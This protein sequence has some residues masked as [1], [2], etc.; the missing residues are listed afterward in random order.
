MKR[1]VLVL[2]AVMLSASACYAET[3]KDAVR[4]LKKLEARC[5]AGISYRDYAPA[6]GD[7]KFD[8]NMYI[9]SDEAKNAPE[10]SESIKSAISHYEYA[11]SF[12]AIKFRERRVVDFIDMESIGAKSFLQRYPNPDN[13]I[14]AE[15]QN[16]FWGGMVK[17]LHIGMGVQYIFKHAAIETDKSM[18]LLARAPGNETATK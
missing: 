5:Q 14:F 9:E 4:A 10:L 17:K 11:N 13:N 16:G 6:L 3:A 8:V 1:V 15:I 7:A 12:W 18:K 2:C